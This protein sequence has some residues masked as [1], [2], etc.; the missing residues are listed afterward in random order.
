MHV[1]S[2]AAIPLLLDPSLDSLGEAYIK[3]T[4]DL[5]GRLTDIIDIA[6]ALAKASIGKPNKLQRVVR[7]FIHFKASDKQSI[8]YHYDVSNE[9]KRSLPPFSKITASPKFVASLVRMGLDPMPD[10]ERE[11]AAKLPAENARWQRI[12][13]LTMRKSTEPPCARGSATAGA[14]TANC[15]C[16]MCRARFYRRAVCSSDP[17][18]WS[19]SIRRTGDS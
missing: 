19:A 3:R 7:Y 4:I 1:K 6:Y 2:P 14:I 10:N 16:V 13:S 8:E 17:Q 5:D 12:V 11:M 9:C 18:Y 15:S